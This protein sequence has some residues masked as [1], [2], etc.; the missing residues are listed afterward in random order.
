L[1]HYV[2]HFPGE[3]HTITHLA[4]H[5]ARVDPAGELEIIDS[6]W[7]KEFAETKNPAL[8]PT[9]VLEA[10]SIVHIGNNPHSLPLL[11]ALRDSKAHIGVILHDLWI[12]DLLTYLEPFQEQEKLPSRIIFNALHAEG[13][14]SLAAL[15]SGGA[16]SS[17]ERG[18]LLGSLLNWALPANAHLIHHGNDET[19]SVALAEVF[20]HESTHF[21]LPDSYCGALRPIAGMT[22]HWDVVISGTGSYGKR[23][24][25][26]NEAIAELLRSEPLRVAIGGAIS[27]NFE[28][29]AG[30]V[31]SSGGAVS[32]YPYLGA[33]DWD[34]LHSQ[35]RVGIR[36]GVGTLGE[37]S[38]LIRD[39]LAYGLVVV[40]D[41]PTP[42]STHPRVVGVEAGCAPPALAEAIATALTLA[43]PGASAVPPAE[44][45][46]VEDYFA[47]ICATFRD[48]E[49][50]GSATS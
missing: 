13:L 15:V 28:E 35:S 27:G 29:L 34:I 26:M 31:Q 40:T 14:R 41:D 7:V 48:C 49:F 21:W 3:G 36:I 19:S 43:S 17:R 22:R 23:P 4:R 47:A 38:G 8:V 32:L 6:S 39:Y 11:R 20:C 16:L 2:A 33:V 45:I 37:S 25:V 30:T 18:R 9:V 24:G 5:V 10:N 42:I 12:F 1:K 46:G 50:R 44:P